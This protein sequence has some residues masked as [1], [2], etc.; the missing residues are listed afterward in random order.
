MSVPTTISSLGLLVIVSIS[1]SAFAQNA[2]SDRD[3]AARFAPVFYQ[4]IGDNARSDYITNFDFDGDWRSDNNWDN[5]ANK[6]YP[7]K[8]YVYY[9]VSETTTH[10]FIHYAVFH[11]RDYKGGTTKGRI[12]SEIL[13]EGTNRV[14]E[15]DPTGMAAEATVAHENDM[16][17]C[18]VV[19][20]KGGSD[21]SRAR[22]VFVET[23]A[24]NKFLKYTTGSEQPDTALTVDDRRPLLYVEPKGHGIQNYRA[25]RRQADAD[26]MVSEPEDAKQKDAKKKDSKNSKIVIYRFTGRAEQ[27]DKVKTGSCGY[28]LV[29]IQ[30]TFWKRAQGEANMTYGATFEY[31]QLTVSVWSKGSVA[32]HKVKIG[33]RGVAFLG[34]RGG[35]N[36]ARAPWG[37]FDVG[38]K[39]QPLGSWFFDPATT[40]QRHFKLGESFSTVYVRH[41]ILGIGN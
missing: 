33:M 41:P 39:S 9:S 3:V 14:K 27:P 24:H 36:I 19:V 2:A 11:A 25:S 30:T 15:F 4:A 40:I 5:V 10:F 23:L 20:E 8:A 13:R 29:P 37:W 12:L 35:Q 21:L 31:P 6:R 32:E 18:L 38:E 26:E 28:D 1:T 16:E 7:L 34:K 22:V 17:G